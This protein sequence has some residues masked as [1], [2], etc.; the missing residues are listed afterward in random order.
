MYLTAITN[1][2]TGSPQKISPEEVGAIEQ[3]PEAFIW[4]C[5]GGNGNVKGCCRAMHTTKKKRTY[6]KKRSAAAAGLGGEDSGA[7]DG[8]GDD[9]LLDGVSL[10][11][12]M[13]M[14]VAGLDHANIDTRL[15]HLDHAGL[16][17]QQQHEH[18]LIMQMQ[19]MQDGVSLEIS[20]HMH[21]PE[22]NL[23][24]D[25]L[26]HH[27]HHDHQQQALQAV[28]DPDLHAVNT[29]FPANVHLQLAQSLN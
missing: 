11:I 15:Q 7:D 21:D 14:G 5:C 8:G 4:S 22:A 23:Q 12:A 6:G 13:D 10:G 28:M 2:L 26:D 9:T 3:S 17:Q 24:Q 29:G 18:E 27:I 25:H 16:Q 19:Q 1:D 20:P